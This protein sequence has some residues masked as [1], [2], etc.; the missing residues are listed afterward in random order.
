MQAQIRNAPGPQINIDEL[1]IAAVVDAF[2]RRIR[3]DVLL[4]PIFAAH[5]DD[6]PAHIE[7]LT[8]FWSSVLMM[9]GRYK[10]T[11]LQNHLAIPHLSAA[12]FERWLGLF[13]DTLADLCTSEQAALFM[14]RA[15][16]IAQSFQ[17]AI[18]Q[19]AGEVP[20]LCPVERSPQDHMKGPQ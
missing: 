12:H 7:K 13:A 2:Y 5:V 14:S 18:A 15:A 20:V 17:M 8:R 19:Q 6:W 16:R 3:A 4:G 9:S 10:G 1:L 11:P